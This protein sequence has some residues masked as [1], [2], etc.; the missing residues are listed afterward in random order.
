MFIPKNIPVRR[1]YKF[2]RFRVFIFFVPD[3]NVTIKQQKKKKIRNLKK[4]PISHDAFRKKL[5]HN[6]YAK[7]QHS[8]QK[9][10]VHVSHVK[11]FSYW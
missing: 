7:W 6:V 11:L 8:F 10:P 1:Q 4:K 2:Q 3:I 5:K 9:Y